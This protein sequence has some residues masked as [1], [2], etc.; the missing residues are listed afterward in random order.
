MN[1]ATLLHQLATGELRAS[2][3][4]NK[5]HMAAMRET[6]EFHGRMRMYA[7]ANPGDKRP[8]A[9]QLSTPED[10]KQAYERIVLIRAARQMEEDFG[11][12]DDLLA[13]FET[14]VIGDLR[15]RA[16]TGNPDADREINDWLEYQFEVVDWAQKLDIVQ[17]AMLAIRTM[18]RDGEMGAIY[19]DDPEV[20]KLNFLSADRIG[21]PLIATAIGP[22]NYNGIFV[23]DVS[24]APVRYD[25]WRRLP[26]LNAYVFQESVEPNHFIHY[27]DP[28]RFEQYH[29]V[30]IFK[31]AI[32]NG[33]DLKQTQDFTRLNIKWRSSQLPF[34]RNEQGRPKG[35]GANGYEM[36][37][38]AANGQ[39]RPMSLSVDGVTQ[40]FIKLD[41]DIIEYPND[42][43]NQQY[44]PWVENV[45]RDICMSAKLPLEFVYRSKT[46]GVVQR[47][48]VEK[49]Q[50]TFARDKRLIKWVLLNPYKNRCIEKGI[51]TGQLDLSRFGNL[52]MSRQRFAG[53]WQM[54]RAISV[55]YGRETDADLKQMDIGV[56]SEADYVLE[57]QGRTIDQIREEKAEHARKIFAEAKKIAE[58]TGEDVA[59]ILPFLC[60]KFP[61]PGAGLKAAGESVDEPA[62]KDAV[63]KGKTGEE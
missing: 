18:K 44:E 9:N 32:E 29:G 12:F 50:A 20:L 39:P 54:G 60:K 33:F 59:V 38:P 24:G 56:M 52:A 13:E 16:S 58:E 30:T 1:F 35:G 5:Q 46:G 51:R 47:F 49:A 7:G 63:D 43:P 3:W 36:P 55:D 41:E 40:T 14:F 6:A 17:A 37:Q 2:R 45:Q 42:F 21:N 61:N 34:A 53:T 15:Y 4:R 23:D 62:P 11:F 57:T 8:S 31:N 10:Y 25:I 28:F 19:I 27:C 48:Y 26:K 22:K